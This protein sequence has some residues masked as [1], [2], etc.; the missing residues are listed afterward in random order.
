MVQGPTKTALDRERLVKI[1]L[2]TRSENDSEA[3]AAIRA[4]NRMLEGAGVGW[5]GL[6]PGSGAKVK[7][8]GS[9]PSFVYDVPEVSM[10]EAVEIVER[11][12]S[13]SHD[14][15]VGIEDWRSTRMMVP[16]MRSQLYRRVA[17]I[18]KARG[19]I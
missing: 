17:E 7:V 16:S 12:G 6:L 11:D 10:T 1:L 2:R 8:S 5:A 14:L 9:A 15:M 4:A 19:D 3:L 18:L 13:M